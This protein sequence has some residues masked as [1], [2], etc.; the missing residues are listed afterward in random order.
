MIFEI[1]PEHISALDS[2]DLVRL[3]KRLLLAESQLAGIPL[4]AA[5]V[6]LQITVPDG[7]ED[8]R[9]EW[10]DGQAET[11][12][13]PSR[14]TLFQ[15]K[16]QNLTAAA[17]RGEIIKGKKDEAVEL[18]EAIKDV[19]AREGAYIIFCSA[20]FTTNKKKKLVTAVKTAIAEGGGDAKRAVA[21][22]VY[23][24][25]T[26]ADWTNTHPPVALWLASKRL[27]R[28]LHGFQTHE[29][30]GR[31]PEIA[32]V[33]WQPSELPRFVPYNQ[34]ERWTYD[35]AAAEMR[36]F[37]SNDGAV[38]RIA[39]PSG[40]GKTRFVYEA[41]KG[42]VSVL[43]DAI[44]ASSVMWVEGSI[45]GEQTINLALEMAETLT[46]GILVVDECSDDLDWKLREIVQRTGSK[47]RLIT[48]NTE[49]RVTA[50]KNLLSVR[51]EKTDH[52]HIQAIAK[53]VAP[54]LEEN[55]TSFIADFAGGFPR[56]AVLAAQRHDGGWNPLDTVS[57]VIDRIIWGSNLRNNDAQRALEIASLFD[58]F[59]LDGRVSDQVGW[60][61]KELGNMPGDVFAEHLRSFAP[62]GI[63]TKRGDFA[64]ISPVPL[65]ARLGLRRLQ[66]MS[67]DQLIRLFNDA[68]VE[69][70]ASFLTRLKWLDTSPIAIE[71]AV[72]ILGSNGLGNLAALNTE[73]GSNVL[74]R[75][76][77]VNPEAVAVAI[78]RVFGPLSIDE[79]KAIR[80]GR[81]HLVWTLEKLVFLKSNFDR[82][83]T[84]LRRLAVVETETY[85]NNA[86]GIFKQLFH[87]YL[88]GTEAEPFRRLLVLDEGLSSKD[89]S[90][91]ALCVDALGAMLETRHFSRS[92][93]SDQIGSGKPLVDWQPATNGEIWQ[94][95]RSAISRL[96]P[97]ATSDDLVAHNAKSL[98]G[99][100]IRGLLQ[101]V[102][103]ED[104]KAMIDTIVAQD[105]VW[106]EA[107][108][109]LSSWLFFDRNEAPPELARKVRQ[110]YDALLPEDPI[111]LAVLY[112]EGWQSDLNDP[113]SVYD[114]KNNDFDYATREAQKVAKQ[115]AGDPILVKRAVDRL[116]CGT[117]QTLFPFARELVSAVEDPL[118]LFSYAVE[119][120]ES[121][122]TPANRGFFSGIISGVDGRDHALAQTF[123]RIAL[124]ATKLK[125]DAISFIGSGRLQPDDL[126]LVI[127]LLKS[128]DVSPRE[129]E[130]LSYGRGLDHLTDAEILPLLLEL[131]QHGNEGLWSIL[132]ILNMVF[133]SGRQPTKDL[134]KFLK[135]ILLD[136]A[137]LERARHNMDG[138]HLVWTVEWVAKCNQIKA[139]YAKKLSKQLLRICR[140]DAHSTFNQLYGSVRKCLNVLARLHPSLVWEEVAKKLTSRSWHDRACADR[141]LAS[142][143][144]DDYLSQGIGLDIPPG[145]FVTWVR[146]APQERAA[147]AVGW[148]PVAVKAEDG[149]L[150]WHPEMEAFITEFADQPEVLPAVARRFHPRSW[151]GSLAPYL[152][153]TLPLIEVWTTHSNS[154][155]R[156]F[157]NE[158]NTIL[159]RQ[160]LEEKKRS[161]ERFIQ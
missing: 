62:R 2:L 60:I 111:E 53:G 10:A 145:T 46:P 117:G 118:A 33:P 80:D 101:A 36:D 156:A 150:R 13:F 17:V 35:R 135:T 114:E 15:S 159:R 32:A 56:M 98:L 34:V 144:S 127:G 69:L 126:S 68:P 6:P 109:G 23:D 45:S 146:A 20:P 76:V 77:E 158:I 110:F 86:G 102:P 96:L 106:I 83:A 81:R 160:I 22:L 125:K 90:E 139:S 54:E 75:L 74:N 71:F 50:A 67:T 66:V 149:V 121:S 123:V 21:I 37:L 78:E 70:K 65:A 134:L 128:G 130:F 122:E 11:G 136:S 9:V 141:L 100:H 99:S 153:A 85:A 26:I 27:G 3:M 120:A 108:Q 30:R 43:A 129:T 84:L 42:D 133:L 61:A 143:R 82:A 57:Q 88:S 140:R 113:D 24:A 64:Q 41:L 119:V 52:K 51:I 107:I 132:G 147:K 58:W 16:A 151:Y 142:L 91:R 19:L 89:Q 18:K 105:G 115:I 7:G 48:M 155:V 25:N 49:T 12:Y 92:G 154:K 14:F 73:F 4:R 47:L 148:L 94:F 5:N 63:L 87:L 157:A 38:I 93:G 44:Y 137:L 97:I 28:P 124:Q 72:Q 104:V 161:E 8:G 138:H 116:T 95:I 103:F 79:L 31:A 59:G 152:E 1:E 39:G 55:N 131:E 112:T 29:S 40:Y